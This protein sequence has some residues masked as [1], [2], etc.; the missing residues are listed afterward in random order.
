VS[1]ARLAFSFL[2]LHEHFGLT[3]SSVVD[4]AT[5]EPLTSSDDTNAPMAPDIEPSLSC[6]LTPPETPP[7]APAS[8]L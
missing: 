8:A 6:R 5:D 1:E 7:T 2:P 4:D 3:F